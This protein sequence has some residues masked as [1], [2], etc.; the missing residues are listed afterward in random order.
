[1][2]ADGTQFSGR[3]GSGFISRNNDDPSAEATF[4]FMLK[5]GIPRELTISWNVVPWWNGIRKVTRAELIDGV[6]CVRE[7]I[8]LLPQLL[9]VV[10]V[11]GKAANARP[12]LESTGLRLF[13]SY[14][15]SPL[16]KARYPERWNT[17]PSEWAKVRKFLLEPQLKREGPA[18]ISQRTES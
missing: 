10:M 3:P 11:G 14:H 5:A 2:T 15:P 4:E 17:I 6:K 9:A 7:L 12:Y 16:V 1:M 13:T 8:L 18:A